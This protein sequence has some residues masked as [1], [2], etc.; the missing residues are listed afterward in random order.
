MLMPVPITLPPSFEEAVGYPRGCRWVALYWEPCGDEAMYDDGYCSGDGNDWGLLSFI[1]HPKI[2]PW[3]KGYDI[4]SSDDEAKD[5]LLC[6]LESRALFI[7][8]RAE[9]R[10]KLTL[11][12]SKY[13]PAC[14]PADPRVTLEP[15]DMTELLTRV[16]EELRQVPPPT[17]VEIKE[18]MDRKQR[19][20]DKMVAELSSGA[21]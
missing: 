18:S 3:L 9:A 20:I 15:E 19:A 5:W 14:A 1:R 12:V 21:C 11:E 13:V 17:A 8:P 10:E 2:A 4:G 6:D 16:R 7:G